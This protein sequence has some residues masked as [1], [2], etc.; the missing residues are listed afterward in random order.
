M[1]RL[2]NKI[3][4]ISGA[5]GMLGTA[6]SEAVLREKGKVVAIDH[7]SS[8]LDELAKKLGK[9]N[10]VL[11]A[12]L[13]ISNSGDV[14]SF[15]KSIP[16][17]FQP[18]CLVNNAALN[19]KV[20]GAGL[21][22][23]TIDKISKERWDNEFD[24]GLWGAFALSREFGAALIE[25]GI[26][27]LIVNVGSDYS[28]IAPKQSLYLEPNSER[29]QNVKPVTYPVLKHG[30]VGLTRYLATYWSDNAI[31]VVTLSP[32]GIENGQPEY[33]FQNI[34]AEVPMKRMARR[35]EIAATLA[36]LLSD[37]ASYINGTELVVDGG[38]EIW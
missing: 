24:V 12:Q 18:N 17:D 37:D 36:F 31:R 28:H 6:F 15:I 25:R 35:E 38:R 21:S 22:G 9:S 2:K 5:A 20:E 19:P 23:N 29:P 33:F 8:A 1:T 4:L 7:S 27:G 14:S 30:I 10:Q 3:V 34:A 11:F 32:G 16:Q 26:P 13:D